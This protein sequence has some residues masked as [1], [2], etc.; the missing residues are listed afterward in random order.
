[1]NILEKILE[2]ARQGFEVRILHM[3]GYGYRLTICKGVFF[4]D[5]IVDPE[6]FERKKIIADLMD[7]MV[8][9]INEYL[10]RKDV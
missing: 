2:L 5:H 7:D 1:M 9:E 8:G 3:P 6:Y 4:V 10:K